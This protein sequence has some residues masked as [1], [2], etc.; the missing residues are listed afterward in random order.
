MI[1]G[2]PGP[3]ESRYGP[4]WLVCLVP[5]DP[6]DSETFSPCARDHDYLVGNHLWVACHRALSSTSN[7][8]TA[9]LMGLVPHCHPSPI[10]GP[11]LI[12]GTTGSIPT[13]GT[14]V[15]RLQKVVALGQ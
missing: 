12:L 14:K 9:E 11:K 4:Q 2:A 8:E 1:S 5:F 13:F 6:V 10:L 15:P 3:Y 7:H